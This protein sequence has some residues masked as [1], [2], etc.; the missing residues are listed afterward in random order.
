[1][2]RRTVAGRCDV[3]ESAPES[4]SMGWGIWSG[5]LKL[6]IAHPGGR[7]VRPPVGAVER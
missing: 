7:A 5:N 2:D 6:A 3:A 4:R 1:M